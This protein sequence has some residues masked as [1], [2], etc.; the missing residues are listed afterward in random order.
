MKNVLTKIQVLPLTLFIL[1]MIGGST[2]RAQ[3]EMNWCPIRLSDCP[4]EER[5]FLVTFSPII[6]PLTSLALSYTW[7]LALSYTWTQNHKM[8]VAQAALE[9][10]AV[11]YDSGRLTGVLPAVVSNTKAVMAQDRGVSCSEISDAEAVDHIAGVAE[12]V[13]N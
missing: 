13:L 1:A 12:A 5:A 2:N 4:P 11:Y 3:A 10:V 6:L 9:D 8:A 7:T